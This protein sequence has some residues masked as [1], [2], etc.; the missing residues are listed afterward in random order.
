VRLPIVYGLLLLAILAGLSGLPG[1]GPK[2]TDQTPVPPSTPASKP[3]RDLAKLTVEQRHF[4][5]SGQRG[6]DWLQRSNKP[7]GRFL[8]GYLPD[9]RL[10]M[11]GDSYIRQAGAAL[12]LA[13]SAKFYQDERATAIARQA[14]LTLLLETSVDAKEPH[15]RSVPMHLGNSLAA[16]G[17]LLAAIHELPA[18]AADLLDQGDQLA[19]GL[20]KYLKADGSLNLAM[21][22]MLETAS[23]QAEALEHHTGPALLG[24]IRSQGFRPATWKLEALRKACIYYDAYWKQHKN[25]PMVAEHSAAYT[26]AFLITKESGFAQTVFDMNDWLCSLQVQQGGAGQA[27]WVGGFPRDD[28]KS[29][30]PPDI[31]SARAVVSLVEA[32]RLAKAA[33]D[34]RHY[35]RYRQAAESGLQFLTTLQYSEANTQHFADW[36]RSALVGAFHASGQDGSVRLDHAQYALA[37]LVHY[38]NDVADLP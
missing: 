7:D 32:C 25:I 31:S 33:G 21:P 27:A 13:R 20:R 3:Q 38:L 29:Q 17:T 9:L 35:Q 19:N 2:I 26:E 11:E 15:V 5:L 37:A 23:E 30:A 16:A 14:L 18:P 4:Y 36:Y 24:I 12:A 1:Q 10:P 28:G 6:M 34:L 8:Y 22:G